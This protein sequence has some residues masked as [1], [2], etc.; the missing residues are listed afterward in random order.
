M[1]LHLP[2]VDRDNFVPLGDSSVSMPL[3]VMEKYLFPTIKFMDY[4]REKGMQSLP[5]GIEVMALYSFYLQGQV[6][7][8]DRTYQDLEALRATT[9]TADHELLQQIRSEVA[10]VDTSSNQMRNTLIALQKA[11][12]LPEYDDLMIQV[13]H[14][15]T[16]SNQMRNTLI[17]LQKACVLPEYDDLMMQGQ[18]GLH[19]RQDAI[20]RLI[21]LYDVRHQSDYAATKHQSS[22]LTMFAHLAQKQAVE[23][24]ELNLRLLD[25]YEQTGIRFQEV[26]SKPIADSQTAL[27]DAI[28]QMLKTTATQINNAL[29]SVQDKINPYE[30]Q[31]MRAVL[32]NQKDAL[33]DLLTKNALLVA[34]NSQLRSHLSLMPVQYRDFATKLQ[35]TNSPIYLNQRADPKVIVPRSN[36]TTGGEIVLTGAPMPHP[37]VQ[38][39]LRDAMYTSLTHAQAAMDRAFK[40]RS[41]LLTDKGTYRIPFNDSALTHYGAMPHA[42]TESVD[43]SSGGAPS[44]NSSVYSGPGYDVI[45]GTFYPPASNNPQGNTTSQHTDGVPSP[46]GQ[47]SAP[48]YYAKGK[49]QLDGA[50]RGLPTKA[51]RTD[52]NQNRKNKGKGKFSSSHFP[53][54]RDTYIPFLWKHAVH[55]HYDLYEHKNLPK[56]GVEFS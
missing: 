30:P 37:S 43:R 19:K 12:V 25:A 33:K 27:H 23:V 10:H 40:L 53:R 6:N 35:A 45:S 44:G 49:R 36:H 28:E 55:S 3:W 20:D 39:Y 22:Q 2:T 5:G 26:I 32:D 54:F 24:L 51:Q 34:E 41:K 4:C 7:P 48:D 14:V 17:A 50:G 31:D 9:L 13:A 1:L 15:D 42:T 8:R 21:A 29:A 16:S 11:C 46:P 38:E 56:K 18:E 47:R 52:Q